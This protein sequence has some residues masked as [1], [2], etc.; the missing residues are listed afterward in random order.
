[1][2]RQRVE[3]GY[4]AASSMLNQVIKDVVARERYENNTT[5]AEL[6]KPV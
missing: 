6:A 5:L 1:V 3:S 4:N 2:Q